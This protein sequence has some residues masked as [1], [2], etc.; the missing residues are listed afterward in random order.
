MGMPAC[1]PSLRVR[2]APLQAARLEEVVDDAG[3]LLGIGVLQF[4]HGSRWGASGPRRGQNRRVKATVRPC[5]TA[6]RRKRAFL[7]QPIA[8]GLSTASGTRNASSNESCFAFTITGPLSADRA[9]RDSAA[10]L[11]NF[12]TLSIR[13]AEIDV[14]FA[15]AAIKELRRHRGSLPLRAAWRGG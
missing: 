14:Q 12:N 13:A 4:R 1:W 10:M 7:Q 11:K 8:L 15:Y 6:A 3:H 2:R 5:G 9:D